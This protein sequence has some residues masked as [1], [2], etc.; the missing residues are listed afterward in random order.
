MQ[1]DDED[2]VVPGFYIS[3]PLLALG[4]VALILAVGVISFVQAGGK[5]AIG[6]SWLGW[7]LP[8][9]SLV[10]EPEAP[11][12]PANGSSQLAIDITVKDKHQKLMDGAEV[13]VTIERGQG[14][15]TT[16]TD[17]PSA[18]SKRVWLRAP[19]QSQSIVVA[20]SFHGIRQVTTVEAFDPQP[21]A[22][23]ALKA[24]TDG[25]VISTATPTL[26]GQAPIGTQVEV[27]VDDQQNTVLPVDGSGNF[28]GPLTN[29]IKRGRHALKIR[30]TN[31]Y[32]IS[33]A[34]TNPITVE[35]RTPDPEIDIANLRIKPNPAQAGEA[36]YIFV[37]VSSNTQSVKLILENTSHD[38][39]DRNKSSIYSA[40]LRAPTAPGLYPLSLIVT[41]QGGD[42]V[43]AENIAS[44]KVR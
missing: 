39:S 27:Y 26:S 43:L 13:G 31:K 15:L 32:G 40:A 19:S 38:L 10:V 22:T 2:K 7:F 23:P 21:P 8:S 3:R 12:L 35:I 6:K 9:F 25:A 20:V 42:S 16:A 44:L 24:P 34:T 11:Y 37:P 30:A 28:A 41:N 29:A 33:S 17:A 36:F 4:L 5:S 1:D 18:V 14:D